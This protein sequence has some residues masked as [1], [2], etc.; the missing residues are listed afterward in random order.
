MELILMAGGDLTEKQKSFIQ[1]LLKKNNKILIMDIEH[2]TKAEGS[3]LISFLLGKPDAKN[4]SSYLTTPSIIKHFPGD[5][6]S[7]EQDNSLPF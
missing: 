7:V 1:S 4:M 5:L 6:Y 2:L 3:S